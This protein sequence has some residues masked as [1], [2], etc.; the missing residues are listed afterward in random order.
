MIHGPEMLI[1]DS[2]AYE[3]THQAVG[4]FLSVRH[5]VPHFTYDS[6]AAPSSELDQVKYC[7]LWISPV[8][9]TQ[10]HERLLDTTVRDQDWKESTI[11]GAGGGHEDTSLGEEDDGIFREAVKHE[12]QPNPTQS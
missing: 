6:E 9:S 8:L 1:A 12:P 3:V 5:V 7:V 2:N 4:T 10:S 11:I